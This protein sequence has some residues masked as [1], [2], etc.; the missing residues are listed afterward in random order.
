MP[1][2][3]HSSMSSQTF[4]AV[5]SWVPVGQIHYNRGCL[6]LK[7][8]LSTFRAKFGQPYLETARCVTALSS[9]TK[10]VVDGTL[11]DVRA[12]LPSAVHLVAGIANATVC[13]QQVLASSVCA[14]IGILSA[15][16]DICPVR[17]KW[18]S[19]RKISFPTLFV[20]EEFYRLRCEFC[21]SRTGIVARTLHC[22]VA[23]KVDRVYPNPSA[24]QESPYSNNNWT[25]LP[26]KL[27]DSNIG[28]HGNEHSKHRVANL[29]TKNI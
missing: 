2:S 23:G 29:K 4:V 17:N 27:K 1:S 10:E 24:G 11:V 20:L 26:V 5:F 12:R 19:V 16:V 9:V 14:N 8:I 3:R 13:A 18:N 21:L 25:L 28:R 7:E 22:R 6:I 15:L